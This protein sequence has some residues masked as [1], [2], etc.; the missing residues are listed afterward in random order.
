MAYI[1]GISDFKAVTDSTDR[2]NILWFCGVL[3]DL[4]TNLLDM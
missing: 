1:P 2:L 3:L 4:L